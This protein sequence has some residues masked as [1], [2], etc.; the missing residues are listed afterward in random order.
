M[1]IV[2]QPDINAVFAIN[3]CLQRI[4]TVHRWIRTA[5]S[6][7]KRENSLLFTYQF[8]GSFLSSW[9]RIQQLKG[10]AD[11]CGSGSTTLHLSTVAGSGCRSGTGTGNKICTSISNNGQLKHLQ[12]FTYFLFFS[13]LI[14]TKRYKARIKI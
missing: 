2:S 8:C 7:S 14:S 13:P 4:E 12:N 10:N 9:I 6:T 1:K 5:F 11:P 3:Y